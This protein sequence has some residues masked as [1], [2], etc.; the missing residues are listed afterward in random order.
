MSDTAKPK[1]EFRQ[2]I[3]YATHDG[4]ELTGRPLSAGRG[5]AVP[6]HRQRAWRLLAARRARHL[7]VLG[8]V[9]GRAR[10]CGLHHQLPADQAGKKT[11]PGGGARRARRGAVHARRAPRNSGS[12]PN[13]SRCGATPRARSSPPWWRSRATARCSR[14]AIRR[15][16]M[17]RSRTSVKVLIGT[18]GIYDLLAQW[19]HAQ[20]GNPG[21]Q[22]GR[23]AISA[24]RRCRIAAAIS[25]PRRISHAIIGNNKT[26][27]FL[28]W[29]TEDDVVD[30]RDAVA[31]VPA[32]AQ[33]GR[34]QRAHLRDAWRAALLAQRSDRGA[35]QPHRLPGAAAAAVPGRAAVNL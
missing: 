26:A 16:P 10:L 18:Y 3:V 28:S 1:T 8:T 13:A 17:P 21:R 23:I 25:T 33:A 32:G 11:Y 2:N 12:I 15:I 19:R 35:R 30:H 6:A 14:P 34:L 27:V 20:I 29:G 4:V 7:P 24:A 31:R 5:R 9:S 22:S